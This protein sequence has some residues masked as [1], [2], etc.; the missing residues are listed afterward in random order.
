MIIIIR[1]IIIII[2]IIISYLLLLSMRT[3]S[4]SYSFT[5]ILIRTMITLF[6]INVSEGQ[7]EQTVNPFLSM[8]VK[9]YHPSHEDLAEVQ[10]A[11]FTSCP[12]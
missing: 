9:D 12:G 7:R 3:K 2:I 5:V 8:N 6:F 1:V 10:R 4:H 11:R